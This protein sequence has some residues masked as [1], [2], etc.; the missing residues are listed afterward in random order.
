MD[1]SDVNNIHYNHDLANNVCRL[2]KN[3]L[4]LLHD[5]ERFEKESGRQDLRYFLKLHGKFEKFI[6][7][8]K[9]SGCVDSN[10]DKQKF[11]LYKLNQN[12]FTAILN[13]LCDL[14]YRTKILINIESLTGNGTL[15]GNINEG[16]KVQRSKYCGI[17][18]EK[19]RIKEKRLLYELRIKEYSSP[20]NY[21]LLDC[22]TDDSKYILNKVVDGST[23]CS[24]NIEFFIAPS[25]A[26]EK[27]H[28][29]YNYLDRKVKEVMDDKQ[30]KDIIDLLHKIAN[31]VVNVEELYGK[32]TESN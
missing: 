1:H 21:F 31:Y 25:D 16:Y 4:D 6:D 30:M 29:L 14:I 7:N 23:S 26:S 20:V 8:I 28:Y 32:I 19:Q 3:T 18:D 15:I 11:L 10:G 17:G 2:F 5:V 27:D 13:S 24:N 12:W 22:R 9:N